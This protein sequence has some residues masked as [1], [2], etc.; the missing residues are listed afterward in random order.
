MFRLHYINYRTVL[1]FG[2]ISEVDAAKGLARVQFPDADGIVSNWLP[3]SVPLT[4]SDKFSL[5]F[6]VNEHV[7][8]LMDEELEY[9]VIGGAIYSSA[10]TPGSLGNADIVGMA[11]AHGLHIQY[12]RSDGTLTISGTGKLK[13]DVTGDV[14]IVSAANV[15]IT[16]TTEVDITAPVI[17]ATGAMQVVGEITAGGINITTGLG[18]GSGKM[19][20]DG[21]IQTTGSIKQG[22]VELGTH[23]HSGVQT[24]AGTS[25]PPVP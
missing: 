24:G 19:I 10:D 20:G 12:K 1:K 22:T 11:F 21:D 8:C 4:L 16:A 2:I 15:K 7:W 14:E 13:V 25:G 17:K 18:G 5:P 9:G 23:V 6:F 3:M